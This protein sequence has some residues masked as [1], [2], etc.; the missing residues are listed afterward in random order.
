MKRHPH[1]QPLSRQHHNGL[2]IALLLSKG[3]R[4]N[5][6][7][8][9]MMDFISVNWKEDLEE[10]FELEEHVLLPALNNTSFSQ[11]LTS[12]LLDEH[13]QLREWAQ[14]AA[15]YQLSSEEILAFSSLLDRHI[16]FEERVFFPAAEEALDENELNEIGQQL[17][18][19][20]THNCINYPIKFWE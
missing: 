8:K 19:E 11:Q 15:T 7:P 20:H 9:E 4:K 10:H 18:E 2:L 5:A 3:V 12:Q 1:L 6:S 14:K 16:R 17:I 13:R